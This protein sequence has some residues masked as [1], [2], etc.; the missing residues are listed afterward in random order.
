MIESL[1]VFSL[2]NPTIEFLSL[3]SSDIEDNLFGKLCEALKTN[4]TL[5]FL[6]LYDNKITPQG[7][8][9]LLPLLKS[10]SNIEY[11]G[12]SRNKLEKWEDIKPLISEIGRF[13]LTQA[14]IDEVRA[15]EKEKEAII[16]KNAKVIN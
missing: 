16:M 2:A 8:L 9:H 12:L 14:Q 10:E 1:N 6:E 3:R 13:P 7:I 5:K 11:L 15:K 4:T